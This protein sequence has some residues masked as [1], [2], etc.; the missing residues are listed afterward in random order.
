[1]D[2]SNLTF[3]YGSHAIIAISEGDN[4]AYSATIGIVHVV[5]EHSP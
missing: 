2:C 5:L 4:L 1:M 3:D